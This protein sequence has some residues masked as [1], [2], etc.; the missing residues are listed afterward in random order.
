M[1]AEPPSDTM[2]EF[3]LFPKLPVE[4]QILVCKFAFLLE[5]GKEHGRMSVYYRDGLSCLANALRTGDL[6]AIVKLYVRILPESNSAVAYLNYCCF[7]TKC[8]WN[9]NVEVWKR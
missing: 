4:I 8:S 3:H 7:E 5:V 9:C 1:E 6:A 2:D